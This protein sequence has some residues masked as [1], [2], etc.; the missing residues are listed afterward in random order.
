MVYAGESAIMAEI[1]QAN[2][3]CGFLRWRPISDEG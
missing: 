2:I 1:D 3:A